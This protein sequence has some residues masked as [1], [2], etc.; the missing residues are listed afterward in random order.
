MVVLFGFRRLNAAVEVL[1]E[2]SRF[3]QLDM[4]ILGLGESFISRLTV[5]KTSY[6]D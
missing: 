1:L 3:V 4:W 2:K 6:A 5:V